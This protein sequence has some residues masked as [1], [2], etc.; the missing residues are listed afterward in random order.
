MVK[1]ADGE[2]ATKR[3]AGESPEGRIK[4]KK[5]LTEDS[6]QLQHASVMDVA[7]MQQSSEVSTEAA[8]TPTAPAV[9]S[10]TPTSA[11]RLMNSAP[12][13]IFSP[14]LLSSDMKNSEKLK[15]SDMTPQVLYNLICGQDF[16]LSNL[17]TKVKTLEEE[18]NDLRKE[19]RKRP[20][21]D[22]TISD[23]VLD[24][25]REDYPKTC[26]G[27]AEV[28]GKIITITTDFAKLQEDINSLE[29]KLNTDEQRMD[30]VG[31]EGGTVQNTQF[32]RE[33]KLITDAQQIMV[34]ENRRRHLEGEGRDQYSMRDTVRITGVPY[35]RDENTNTLVIR[36]ACRLGVQIA[37][38]DISVSH[39]TGR[40]VE[41]QP[42]AIICRF[43]R[44]DVKYSL[45]RNKKLARNITSDDD[46]NPVRIF[47]DEKLT[48]MRARVCKLLRSEK[49]Q[50]HTQDGKIFIT[51]QDSNEWKVLDTPE[52]WEGWDKSDDTKI[53]LGVYP[54]I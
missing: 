47:I 13:N 1:V 3:K 9:A 42:R 10:Q 2:A 14:I 49:V 21:I 23:E 18:N 24:K 15:P 36:I 6:S 41:G 51:Q 31:G 32:S 54:R 4:P 53:D 17:E 28:E 22:T 12:R 39:R 16:R 27:L 25:I 7:S 37:P 11:G 5:A 38:Q 52:E 45:I 34:K 20:P 48:P 30:Q 19:L 26:D 43:T 46:G 44:R 40:R 33:L 50:H 8:A 35:N 29:D